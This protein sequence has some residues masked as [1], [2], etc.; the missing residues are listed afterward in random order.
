MKIR[1]RRLTGTTSET[2]SEREIRNRKAARRAAAEGF[3]LL[4]N[5]NGLLPVE[6]GSRIALY[7]AGAGRT[8][9]GGTGSGDVNERDSISIYQGLVRAGYEITSEQWVLA[10]DRLY[11]EERCFLTELG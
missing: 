8:I 7:G 5:R 11:E 6:K 4:R 9:K 2:M 10:Y 1:E 3:V